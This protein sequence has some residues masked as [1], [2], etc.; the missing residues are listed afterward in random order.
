[1]LP[2]NQLLALLLLASSFFFG[3]LAVA[4]QAKPPALYIDK[5]AC[6]FEC[7]TYRTWKTEKN[8][9]AYAEPNKRSKRVGTFKAGTK[10][11]GLT[12][13]VRTR[14]S[15]FTVTKSHETYQPGDVLW[16]YTPLGEGVY[17]VWFKG[18]MLEQELDFVSGPF[19]Q[20]LPRCE[21][22][23]ECW[24]KLDKPLQVEWWVKVR[25]RDGWVGW[26][27]QAENFS[28]MDSCG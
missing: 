16:V 9:V 14:P 15:T 17:K 2:V 21:E 6:P 4:A 27:D 13:E 28:N 8:T 18:K 10:V 11:V 26:T 12:G 1:M 23:V 5:G 25:S 3:E 20:S 7:C 24:G 22:T 19:E